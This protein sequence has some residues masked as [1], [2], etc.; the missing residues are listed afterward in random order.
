M[1][2]PGIYSI[3]ELEYHADRDALSSTWLRRILDSP[4]YLRHYLDSPRTNQPEFDFGHAVHGGVLGVGL[5]VTILDFPDWRTKAARDERDAVYT[6]G[7][8]PM[9]ARDYTPIQ[10]AVEAVKAHPLAGPIFADGTPEMSVYAV[11]PDTDVPLKAR[12]DW[13][14]SDG[15]LYD[16]KTARSGEPHAF[17]RAGRGWGYEVQAAHYCHV[18]ELATGTRPAGFRLV[19]VESGAPHLVDVHEPP[20][21]PEIGEAK[22]AR[23]TALYAE[24]LATNSWPGRPAV[25]NRITS[26]DWAREGEGI[27]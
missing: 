24:C 2:D 10:A 23:G 18:Y 19:T 1:R 9:L 14:G 20:D 27:E 17:E 5:D 6:A 25:I 21:W 11:D 22:R 13:I 12:I 7:G 26:P 16:L 15:Y 3:P 8:V 4:A